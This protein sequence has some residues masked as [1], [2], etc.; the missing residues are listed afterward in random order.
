[1]KTIELSKYSIT[2]QMK[3]EMGNLLTVR[4]SDLLE[5]FDSSLPIG[6]IGP[7]I[8]IEYHVNGSQQNIL[9]LTKS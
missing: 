6:D 5:D 2:E 7:H 9:V 1:V 8:A 4:N 3:K